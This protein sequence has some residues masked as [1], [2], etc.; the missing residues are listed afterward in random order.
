[1]LT[2][3]HFGDL[4]DKNTKITPYLDNFYE[5]YELLSKPPTDISDLLPS[6]PK[7]S[8]SSSSY[9]SSKS[10]NMSPMKLEDEDEEE[11]DVDEYLSSTRGK[12]KRKAKK[13]QK[14]SKTKKQKEEAA[15][16]AI[17]EYDLISALQST[18]H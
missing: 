8:S 5:N 9:V 7:I 1:M 6:T 15:Q 4:N 17:E 3:G 11:E 12:R 10:G 2:L 16:E 14:T 13:K 18:D